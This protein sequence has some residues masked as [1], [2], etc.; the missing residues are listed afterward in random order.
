MEHLATPPPASRTRAASARAPGSAPT[1]GRF[2]ALPPRPGGAVPERRGGVANERSAY[3]GLS[4]ARPPIAAGGGGNI[5]EWSLDTAA[6]A[7]WSG[8]PA[9]VPGYF[10]KGA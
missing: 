2:H 8:A 10:G 9:G 1:L 6:A 7:G 4:P 5:V 3:S